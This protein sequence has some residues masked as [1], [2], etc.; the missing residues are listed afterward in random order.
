RYL[1]VGLAGGQQAGH[2][3]FAGAERQIVGAG[4]RDGRRLLAEGVGDGLVFAEAA[5]VLQR[6]VED[7][8]AEVL[9]G[10]IEAVVATG[11]CRLEAGRYVEHVTE[12]LARAYQPR[13]AFRVAAFRLGQTEEVQ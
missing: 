3:P 1:L 2:F 11:E 4:L 8:R 13:G 5:S 7:T 9:P 12:G 6:L 10:L